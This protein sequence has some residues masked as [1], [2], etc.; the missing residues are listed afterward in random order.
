ML[1]VS[2]QNP[3]GNLNYDNIHY[4]YIVCPVYIV[5]FGECSVNLYF[6]PSAPSLNYSYLG[7]SVYS[8]S[9]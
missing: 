2:C 4:M 5:H 7:K 6:P 1:W 3:V 9:T 8:D